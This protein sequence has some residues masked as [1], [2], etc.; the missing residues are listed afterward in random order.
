MGGQ[1]APSSCCAYDCVFVPAPA[2][3]SRRVLLPGGAETPGPLP[4][5]T[6]SLLSLLPGV[7]SGSSCGT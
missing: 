3:Q 6:K 7:K 4:A 1:R 5:W 2:A